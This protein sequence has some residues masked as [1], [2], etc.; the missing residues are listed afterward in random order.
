[1]LSHLLMLNQR[2][3]SNLSPSKGHV[4]TYRL[5]KVIVVTYRSSKVIVVTNRS[6]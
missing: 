5:S 3:C 1:M 4:V 2:S 6:S